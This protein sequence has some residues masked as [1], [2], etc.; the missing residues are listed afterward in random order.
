MTTDRN[1]IT[2]RTG[3]PFAAAPSVA[4]D[5]APSEGH[6]Q[7]EAQEVQVMMYVAK[8]FPRDRVKAVDKILQDCT[9][10]SLAEGALYE[11]SRGGTNITGP[12]IRL[13]E[14]IAQNW[15]N[16]QFGVR[17]LDQGHGESTM[18]AF[19]WDMESNTRQV[20]IFRVAHVRYS[21]AGGRRKVEDPRDIYEVA[22]NQGARRLRACI[23]GVI[24]GDVVEAAVA[25][26]ENT[27]HTTAD[28][29]PE[30]IKAMAGE[31]AKLG[32]TREMLETRIQRRLDA[33]TP[34]LKIQLGKIF[35]SIR[36]G[37]S[38]PGDWFDT[39]KAAADDGATQTERAKAALAGEQDPHPATKDRATII[40]DVSAATAIKHVNNIEDKYAD[41]AD[42]EGWLDELRD[43]CLARVDVIRQQRG[44]A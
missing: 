6:I 32:V 1:D 14:A 15:G 27:L 22:A 19:A 23:L 39:P 41:R 2:P 4:R 16:I 26:C 36:D 31:F 33:I 29:S 30:N 13:A 28:V 10:P 38:A 17:E 37:M 21:K 43:V 34:A 44:Q 24:P 5:T 7:R 9:R 11:Y 42:A 20:K 8:M 35:T 3:N 18:E 25:E 12:T 40:L